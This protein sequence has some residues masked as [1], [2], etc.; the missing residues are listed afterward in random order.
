MISHFP[1]DMETRPHMQQFYS[2]GLCEDPHKR[3]NNV[4]LLMSILSKAMKAQHGSFLYDILQKDPLS[5]EKHMK[6]AYGQEHATKYTASIMAE[7]ETHQVDIR[8]VLLPCLDH[9]Y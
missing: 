1:I 4:S 2:S 8:L 7:V 9:V 6:Q 5:V 3:T